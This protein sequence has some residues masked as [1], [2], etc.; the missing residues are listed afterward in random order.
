VTIQAPLDSPNE[1]IKAIEQS[2]NVKFGWEGKTMVFRD[3]PPV[4]KK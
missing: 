3:A 2:A 1:A 4:K